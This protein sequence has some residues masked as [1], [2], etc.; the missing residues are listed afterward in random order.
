MAARDRLTIHRFGK[1]RERLKLNYDDIVL[2]EAKS[3]TSS[4]RLRRGPRAISEDGV[5]MRVQE[6]GQEQRPSG[7][8]PPEGRRSQAGCLVFG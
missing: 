6:I 7:M 4:W 1:N 5:A 3:R 2:H 8:R